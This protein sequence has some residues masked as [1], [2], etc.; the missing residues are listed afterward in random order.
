MNTAAST[1]DALRSAFTVCGGPG[2]GYE[3][4]H[5]APPA[6]RLVELFFGPSRLW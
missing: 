5:V 4:K 1:R 2:L 3:S 6:G